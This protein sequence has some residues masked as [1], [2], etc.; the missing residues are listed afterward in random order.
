MDLVA[1]LHALAEVDYE[2]SVSLSEM[3]KVPDAETAARIAFHTMAGLIEAA[4]LRE[5]RLRNAG[6]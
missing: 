4:E 5:Q 6:A 3:A 2:G 1:I